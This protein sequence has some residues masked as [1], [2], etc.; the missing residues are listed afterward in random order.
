[1]ITKFLYQMNV[2][3]KRILTGLVE[4]D[5]D[6]PF[7]FEKEIPMFLEGNV[8]ILENERKIS[9]I[10]KLYYGV[11]KD[12]RD[13]KYVNLNDYKLKVKMNATERV[14]F[15]SMLTKDMLD[16][17]LNNT[18]YLNCE[19][20][21]NYI[22]SGFKLRDNFE[23]DDSFKDMFRKVKDDVY[24]ELIKDNLV[25]FISVVDNRYD[26]VSDFKDAMRVYKKDIRNLLVANEYINRRT[27]R[28]EISMS[29]YNIFLGQ[30]NSYLFGGEN[31]FKV[32]L[33]DNI[34]EIEKEP[35]ID[36]S[37]RLINDELRQGLLRNI[38]Y[39]FK[40]PKSHVLKFLKID[41]LYV[42]VLEKNKYQLTSI[43]SKA[44]LLPQ[45]EIDILKQI[46][47]LY[48]SDAKFFEVEN[49]DEIVYL[50]NCSDNTYELSNEKKECRYIFK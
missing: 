50:Y 16:S 45:T 32:N 9:N 31:S 12:G 25:K 4:N 1:M 35:K 37:Y 30:D 28:S 22:D 26:L 29:H 41:N 20:T 19:Y 43:A 6:E 33:N 21:I 49:K 36:E 34:I 8:K 24:V 13:Y 47:L 27:Q 38:L 46:Y 2:K 10:G 23:Y 18:A 48:N 40:K 14:A 11:F 7:D 42:E 5:V 39:L 15:A 3:N 17:I 44:T